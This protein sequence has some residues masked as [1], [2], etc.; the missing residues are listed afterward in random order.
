MTYAKFPKKDDEVNAVIWEA[1]ALSLAKDAKINT[2]VWRVETILNKQVLIIKRFDRE[3]KNRIPFLSAMSMLQAKDNEQRSYLEIVYS[4][5]EY[6]ASPD[7]DIKELYRR[8][9]FNVLI[10]NT[11][12]HLR[13]H[14]FIY[15]N[16][17]GWRLSHV[18]DI[19]PPPIQIKSIFYPLLLTSIVIKHR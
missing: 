6:G 13:N 14:E 3:N 11:D 5:A 15:E 18:Y 4:L 19:N 2:P 12:D 7:E 9:I 17:E 8:S 16:Q 10:S 1:A